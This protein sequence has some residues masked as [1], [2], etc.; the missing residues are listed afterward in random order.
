LSDNRI[1]AIEISKP[2]FRNLKLNFDHDWSRCAC[3]LNLTPMYVRFVCSIGLTINRASTS[4]LILNVCQFREI[5]LGQTRTRS[6][7]EGSR[8]S[9]AIFAARARSAPSVRIESSHLHSI[10][11]PL[12]SRRST[13]S[14]RRGPYSVSRDEVIYLAKRRAGLGNVTYRARHP[15]S[16]SSPNSPTC[17]IDKS[18][19]SGAVGVGRR[20][21][22]GASV[23]TR[24]LTPHCWRRSVL[25]ACCVHAL[26]ISIFSVAVNVR[27]T[28]L[29]LLKYYTKRTLVSTRRL[30]IYSI[31]VDA[32]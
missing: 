23:Q 9:H 18:K 7:L 5:R 6:G 17:T 13:C 28:Y 26:I 32:L 31:A 22:D 8:N 11:S 1:S 27:I 16:P 24:H 12:T 21:R 10:Y 15:T 19:R 14:I 4:R 2:P 30:L 29:A 3:Y 20:R 25:L